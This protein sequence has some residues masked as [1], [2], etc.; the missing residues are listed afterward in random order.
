MRDRLQAMG[1][2][3]GSV[4]LV[5]LLA[6]AWSPAPMAAQTGPETLVDGFL[7]SWNSHD[8]K[9]FAD[10]FTEDADFVNVAGMWWK[11]RPEIQAR[12]EESHATRF[13]ATSLASTHVSV[14]LPRA[15]VAVIHFG[16]E[17]TGQ[18]DAEGKP[19]PPR[20][21]IMQMLAVKQADGWRITAAQNTN[22]VPHSSSASANTSFEMS[23]A[24]EHIHLDR[25][26]TGGCSA[27]ATSTRG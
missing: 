14:R 26:S 18:L 8:M 7:R 9:A 27:A 11:G 24:T 12:H 16:W 17:L 25:L 19:V 22:S 15:D 2:S 4:L 20:R 21:G 6:L 3:I 1:R 13:R 23:P 10:L 5:V